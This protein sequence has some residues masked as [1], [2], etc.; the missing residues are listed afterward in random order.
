MPR[1]WF[2]WM[3]I[4]LGSHWNHGKRIPSKFSIKDSQ[5]DGKHFLVV[6]CVR[7]KLCTPQ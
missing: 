7:M 2:S 4:G 3:G 1:H 6:K 5:G